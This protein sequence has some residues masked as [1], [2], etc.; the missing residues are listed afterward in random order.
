MAVNYSKVLE[1][2]FNG[3]YEKE[4][5]T[6]LNNPWP[7]IKRE[8]FH[9]RMIKPIEGIQEV[10]EVLYRRLGYI[11]VFFFLT[12]L[13]G[14]K[15]YP[16]PYRN[17]EKGLVVL[18]QLIT[19]YTTDALNHLICKSTIVNI[20]NSFY[21]VDK[22]A[23]RILDRQISKLLLNMFS[24]VRIRILLAKIKNP[25]NFKG[26]T[27]F[28]DG[29]D[30]RL[31]HI[32]ESSKEQYSYKLKKSGYR[33]Q[34]VADINGMVLFVS[35]SL[36]CRQ[37]ADGTM[38][39]EIAIEDFM[40]KQDCLA[41]DGAYK[42]FISPVL[43]R[44]DL[45]EKNFCLPIRKKRGVELTGQEKRSN[46]EFGSF[47]SQMEHIFGELGNIFEVLNGLIIKLQSQQQIQRHLIYN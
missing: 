38:F 37:N 29:H 39:T 12:V 8:K 1:S 27:M 18:Y 45:E 17:L 33:T 44:T 9:I 4:E 13:F 30:T 14:Q 41:L 7:E 15:D 11:P 28:L 36:P 42:H 31:T 16:G 35:E 32:G 5:W 3:I 43:D 34:V 20:S 46:Q 2:D 24:T 6:F 10:K 40:S 21:K 22:M 19:G 26:V 47:R 23:S 25:T